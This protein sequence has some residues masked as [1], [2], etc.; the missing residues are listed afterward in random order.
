MDD[1]VWLTTPLVSD[2]SVSMWLKTT[3]PG[4]GQFWWQGANILYGDVQGL[5]R[6]FG[7]SIGEGG[8]VLFGVG[9]LST[10]LTGSRAVN[11]GQWHHVVATRNGLTAVFAVYVDGVLAGQNARF[12]GPLDVSPTLFLGNLVANVASF[13]GSLD[14]LTVFGVFM[15]PDVVVDLYQGELPSDLGYTPNSTACIVA[16]A[17]N[18]GFPWARLGLERKLARGA[19]PLTS[20]AGVNLTVDDEAPASTIGL[21]DGQYL[22]APAN[23]GNETLI[24]GGSTSDGSGVGVAS[25]EIGAG[26][27]TDLATGAETWMHPISVHEGAITVHSTA[28][29]F[30]G[31]REANGASVTVYGDGTPTISA[32][33]PGEPILPSRTYSGTW[34]VPISVSVQDPMIESTYDGSGEALVELLLQT[35]DGTSLGWQAAENA[36]WPKMT[37]PHYRAPGRCNT[38]CPAPLVTPP[39][40]T[41][42]PCAPPT[43][44]AT[45][46]M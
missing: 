15:Q 23:G 33:L 13:R 11:D 28:I 41:P 24:I 21:T 38:K 36:P 10:S 32:N 8:K 35:G 44:S 20:S 39:A 25:V 19:G 46:A 12:A 3:Q 37:E 42:S 7:L 45:K 16:A 1:R 4:T 18:T 9:G 27:S 17:S 40:A 43:A 30:L 6:R 34:A 2:F 26:G 29:D 14:F 22:K 5:T 31:H